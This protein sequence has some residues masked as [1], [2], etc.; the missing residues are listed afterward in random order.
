[1]LTRGARCFLLIMNTRS[2]YLRLLSFVKPHWFIFL[3]SIICMIISAATEPLF[4]EMLK[5][6]WSGFADPENT[7]VILIPVAIVGL[8]A[9]RGILTFGATYGMSWV[10]NTVI[11]DIRSRMF[12]R[13]I[14]L[15]TSYFDTHS[16]GVLI[17]RIANDVNGVSNAA[18]SALTTIVKDS[19][20]IIALLAYLIYL[21]WQ[22]TLITFVVVPL[23]LIIVRKFSR[24]L[25]QAAKNSQATLGYVVHVLEESI[26]CQRIVKIFGGQNYERQRFGKANTELRHQAMKQTVAAAATVPLTQICASIALSLVI[27][28]ALYESAEGR[29]TVESFVAF[30]TAM[31]LLLSPIKRLADVNTPLQRGLAA[32][33]SV[34]TLLDEL[35][36]ADDG[37]IELQNT[38]GQ[39]KFEGISFCY[40]ESEQPALDNIDLT[41]EPGK[42][43]ALVGASG[44]GKS[45]I[46]SLIPHFYSPSTGRILIDGHDIETLKLASLRK[47]I[48][49]V[50]QEVVLFND[51]IANNIAYGAPKDTPLEKIIDAA[52]AANAWEFIQ[53]MP[54]GIQ[55]MIGEKGLRLS[56]GQRQRIAI[57]RALLKNAPILILDEATSALDTESERKVQ[58]ALNTLM[59]NR[60]TLVIAH[61]LSTIENA[62]TIV[63]MQK[64]RILEQGTHEQLLKARGMYAHLHMLQ[65]NEDVPQ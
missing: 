29:L 53:E 47:Q 13:L 7:K 44:S 58:A 41:I 14:T 20:T 16:S 52:K 62:D 9:L 40:P 38:N 32:A 17:S 48:A 54:D 5:W 30:L 28:F 11:T 23:V 10:S 2:L 35:P 19:V 3:I 46:A 43:V 22:M 45:T 18:T 37:T 6:L 56:G 33:E 61:R 63:V 27:Y 26:S 4:A 50:S 49:L 12:D 51:T 57:A 39:V 42:T 25:R 24:K 55:T 1:M 15:P 60:T 34:F 21:N 36:E 64:G 65:F 8:F 59:Q 31:I